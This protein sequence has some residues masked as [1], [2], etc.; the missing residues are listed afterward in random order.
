[1]S[2]QLPPGIYRITVAGSVEP[3]CLTRTEQGVTIL[4]PGARPDREQEWRVLPVKDGNI[5][6]EKPSPI[7]PSQYL[8]YK[9][10]NEKPEEGD[11]IVY[12]VAEFPPNEWHLV[13][14]PGFRSLIR[15]AGSELGIRIAPPKIHPPILEL[16]NE[17]QLGWVFER[18]R[19]E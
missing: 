4:P 6:I 14:A 3:E 19:G 2:S 18:V 17:R 12:R 11:R 16:G 8:A 10:S 5:I 15:V 13:I 1:M 9:G 7:F